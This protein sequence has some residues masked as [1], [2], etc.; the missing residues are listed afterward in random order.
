MHNLVGRNLET[1]LPHRS[2]FPAQTS[3]AQDDMM[4]LSLARAISRGRRRRPRPRGTTRARATT[5][6]AGG[7]GGGRDGRVGHDERDD[8]RSSSSLLRVVAFVAVD[9]ARGGIARTTMT[10]PT[11]KIPMMTGRLRR[12]LLRPRPRPRRRRTMDT[13]GVWMESVGV[14]RDERRRVNQPDERHESGRWRRKQQQLQLATINKKERERRR[15]CRHSGRWWRD[16]SPGGVG[17]AMMGVAAMTT[18]TRR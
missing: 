15:A 7:G 11:S 9:G 16:G 1:P 3:V 8:D 13:A 12:P 14:T 4:L 5:P 18:M 2:N 17:S 6:A 10:I